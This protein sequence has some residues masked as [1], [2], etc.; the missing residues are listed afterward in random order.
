VGRSYGL[1][2]GLIL[3]AGLLYGTLARNKES[4]SAPA[5]NIS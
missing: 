1:F 2:I 5:S 3:A 4:E